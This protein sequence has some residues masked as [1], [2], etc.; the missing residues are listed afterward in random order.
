VRDV[1]TTQEALEKFHRERGRLAERSR[2][3]IPGDPVI[4]QTRANVFAFQQC[5]AAL[6]ALD[7][8]EQ[9]NADAEPEEWISALRVRGVPLGVVLLESI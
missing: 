4:D 3:G 5:A 8:V 9:L 6:A 7:A 2:R 1:K